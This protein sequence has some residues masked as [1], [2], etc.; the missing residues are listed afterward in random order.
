MKVL[1]IGSLTGKDTAPH[2]Q[3]E[4]RRIAQLREEG[5]IDSVFLKVDRT[6]PI[7]L[8]NDVTADEAAERLAALPFLVENLVTFEYLDLETLAERQQRDA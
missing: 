4:A 8:L 5:L 6:G 2:L 7:L 1:A 3:D